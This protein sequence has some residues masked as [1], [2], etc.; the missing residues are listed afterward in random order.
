MAFF[1]E[2][3]LYSTHETQLK[4]VA[5]LGEPIDFRQDPD[6]CYKSSTGQYHYEAFIIENTIIYL[7]ETGR[8]TPRD[9]KMLHTFL[10]KIIASLPSGP[11][12]LIDDIARLDAGEAAYKSK[13]SKFHTAFKDFFDHIY[14]ITP[15]AKSQMPLNWLPANASVSTSAKEAY[16]QCR[17]QQSAFTN[18]KENDDAE[19]AKMSRQDLIRHLKE[20]QAA[21]R[22]LRENN[23][24]NMPGHL[25]EVQ[26]QDILH[27]L[28]VAVND[29]STAEQLP[30]STEDSASFLQLRELIGHLIDSRDQLVSTLSSIDDDVYVFNKAHQLISS[31]AHPE[32]AV[33]LHNPEEHLG[34]HYQELLESAIAAQLDVVLQHVKNTQLT[35]QFEYCLPKTG[36]GLYFK[37]NISYRKDS[38]GD[39]AGFTMVI[40]EITEEKIA[41]KKIIAS[42]KKYRSV[43]ESVREIILQTNLQGQLA[44]IN[45][46][47]REISAYDVYE[48]LDKSI[49]DFVHPADRT[50]V[51][52]L[53]QNLMDSKCDHVKQ[54]M[55]FTDKFGQI[56][57]VDMFFQ[58]YLDDS[59]SI[60]G[61]SGTLN[62]IT[63]RKK[64]EEVL[65]QSNK[66]LESINKNIKKA[67]KKLQE[68]NQELIKTNQELDR[69]VYSASHD[70][71][72]PLAS[73]LG[74][75]NISRISEDTQE[76]TYYLELMEQSLNRMDKLIQDLTDYSRNARLAIETE[77]INFEHMIKDIFQRLKYLKNIDTVAVNTD[78][79]I[80]SDFHSDKIRLYIILI[81][82]LSN[83]IKYHKYDQPKPYININIMANTQRVVV[84]VADNGIGID[85]NYMD[86][87]FTMF[88]QVSRDA[89]GSGLGL[90]ITRETVNKLHGSIKVTSV[91]NEGTSFTVTIP[92]ATS[93]RY[94]T[95]D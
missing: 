73:T 14:V 43:V 6:W 11:L 18:F 49:L 26:H 51:Q 71:R 69:F 25:S 28:Q 79:A 75:I 10:Q 59:G 50:Y 53:M 64:A 41:D 68:K 36:Y 8:H 81:N 55:R 63:K 5:S 34:I 78:I 52:G 39:Y 22:E 15:E 95:E 74:L 62:D 38:I 90:Y 94:E 48:S 21:N 86:K 46:A 66:L 93:Y 17:N 85:K 35:Q 3:N 32:K 24:H 88:F 12:Y 56:F 84:T 30:M 57:W 87:I 42:E 37:V 27:L 67:E 16:Q 1:D 60:T 19:L 92:N 31:H 40:R 20:A 80:A 65:R 47:W 29:H 13:F 83:A 61:I 58:P 91:I 44:Y 45:P 23:R 82:L 72:A 9:T 77:D 54:E 33:F 70:L 76:R 4:I 2:K 7:K 89:V